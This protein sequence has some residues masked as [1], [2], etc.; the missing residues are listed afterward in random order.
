MNQPARRV[1]GSPEGA[2]NK[3]RPLFVTHKLHSM[4]DLGTLDGLTDRQL[5]ASIVSVKHRD[6]RTPS[7]TVCRNG[8][9]CSYKPHF[10]CGVQNERVRKGQ[11]IEV[12]QF[13][14]MNQVVM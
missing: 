13:R 9:S 14:F 11:I 8:S 3:N 4:L 12:A 7:H 6:Q 2:S 10:F 1:N 5:L